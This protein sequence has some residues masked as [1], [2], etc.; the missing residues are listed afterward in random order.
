MNEI[1]NVTVLAPEDIVEVKMD[2]KR[3]LY[4]T[5]CRPILNETIDYDVALYIF[6][7]KKELEKQF[8]GC[9]G[10]YCDISDYNRLDAEGFL[11][12]TMPAAKTRKLHSQMY[13]KDVQLRRIA[14]RKRDASRIAEVWVKMSAIYYQKRVRLFS[15]ADKAKK[16]LEEG[17]E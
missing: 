16:W 9:L 3:I 15:D 2:D 12:I 11:E 14:Y 4:I 8:G 1:K 7:R 5:F 17:V 10:V 13:K 6:R